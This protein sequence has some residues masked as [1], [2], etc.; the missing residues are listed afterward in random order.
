MHSSRFAQ[1]EALRSPKCK[2]SLIFPRKFVRRMNFADVFWLVPR[3]D[4]RSDEFEW[5]T[6]PGVSQPWNGL[7]KFC[8]WW[9]RVENIHFSSWPNFSPKT[10]SHEKWMVELRLSGS[11]KNQTFYSKLNLKRDKFPEVNFV[12]LSAFT[13]V[14]NVRS[15]HHLQ[16]NWWEPQWSCGQVR[17]L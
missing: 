7:T 17:C 2:G 5:I 15:L 6:I 3:S 16:E 1:P 13:K 10:M 9:L 12:V 11:S 4:F 14:E 8:T